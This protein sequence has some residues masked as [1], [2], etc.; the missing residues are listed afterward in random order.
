MIKLTTNVM[1][2]FAVMKGRIIKK[3]LFPGDPKEIAERLLQIERSVCD[4]ERKLIEELQRTGNRSVNV[5][6]QQRFFGHGFDMEFIKDNKP[7]DLMAIASELGIMEK[8]VLDLIARS[9]LELTKMKL[10]VIDRDQ[11]I[12]QAISSLDDIDDAINKLIERL[13]EWYSLHFPELDDFVKKHEVYAEIVTSG[14]KGLDPD[15]ADKIIDIKKD[16][17]GIKFSDSDICAVR[18]LSGPIVQL[19]SSKKKIEEYIG[20]S[21][22]ETAPNISALAGPLLGARLISLAGGLERLSLMPASTIQIIG[23]EEAFFR[24]LRTKKRPPKH[25]VIFQLPEI[26]SARKTTRGKISRAFAAKLAIAAKVDRFKGE[27]VGD[28]LR[29]DFLKRVAV[30]KKY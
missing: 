30:L 8:D 14:F 18:E 6:N 2:T 13:R 10:K 24:F 19:N 26:R 1:G 9:N 5:I 23:A 20:N 7:C 12:I 3:I 22:D 17:L 25:G 4:E 29:A 11:V 27:F 21:M 28:K 15:F 16:T